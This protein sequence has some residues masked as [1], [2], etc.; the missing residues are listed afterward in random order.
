LE[1]YVFNENSIPDSVIGLHKS[2]LLDLDIM[3]PKNTENKN[4]GLNQ[5]SNRDNHF[6]EFLPNRGS[7]RPSKTPV[8]KS[9]IDE[10]TKPIKIGASRKVQDKSP[11]TK[12]QALEITKEDHRNLMNGYSYQETQNHNQKT[13][14]PVLDLSPETYYKLNRIGSHTERFIDQPTKQAAHNPMLRQKPG[15]NNGQNQKFPQGVVPNYNQNR[16]RKK[17]DDKKFSLTSRGV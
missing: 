10:G 17:S 11:S 3:I 7:K 6:N 4:L 16:K 1:K 2:E 15:S 9:Y 14:I 12:F 8:V 5:M 13:R